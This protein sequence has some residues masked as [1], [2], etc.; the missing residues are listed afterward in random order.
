LEEAL[1]YNCIIIVGDFLGVTEE[2]FQ[3]IKVELKQFTE[4]ENWLEQG[5]MPLSSPPMH[6]LPFINASKTIDSGSLFLTLVLE[7]LHPPARGPED[8]ADE[9]PKIFPLVDV[10]GVSQYLKTGLVNSSLERFFQEVDEALTAHSIQESVGSSDGTTSKANKEEALI[11]SYKEIPSYPIVYSFSS[12]LRAVSAL[13]NNVTESP[14]LPQKRTTNPFAGAA[15][16]AAM[17]GRGF[18]SMPAKKSPSTTLFTKSSTSTV[19]SPTIVS[20]AGPQSPTSPPSIQLTLER[21]LTLMTERCLSIFQG[22]QKALAESMKVLRVVEVLEC[23]S[24][25]SN[26]TVIESGEKTK[27]QVIHKFTTR[28]SYHVRALLTNVFEMG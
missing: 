22:P 24:T 17:I 9:G 4:F 10:K 23:E 26:D 21:H 5:T 2:L 25:A 8:P 18:G 14:T 1:I 13:K 12:D 3:A 16:A 28:Y 19:Q 11:Q 27:V 6:S 15:I 7:K 20:T